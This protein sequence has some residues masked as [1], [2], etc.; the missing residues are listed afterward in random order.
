LRKGTQKRSGDAYARAGVDIAKVRAIHTSIAGILSS[1]FETRR[2]KF[3]EPVIGIG[4]YAGLIE[5][6]G[7]RLLA[8]HTDGV[9]TKVLVAQEMRKF[10]TIGIDCIAVTVNDLV[11]LGSEPVA[12]VDYIALQEEN[13]ALVGELARGLAEGA[14]QAGA[15]IVAGET[16]IVADLIKGVEGYAFDLISMGVGVIEKDS[17]I[18]GSKIREG[19]SVVGISSS[20]LHSNGYTLARRI[21][22]NRSL[23]EEVEE[24]GETI[25]QALLR[26]TRIY[27]APTLETVRRRELHGIANITGGAFSKLTRLVG[28]RALQFKLEQLESASTPPIFGFLKR[29]GNLSDAEMYRTFNMGVGLCLVTPP[30]E[31][32]AVLRDY[33]RRGFDG[34]QIGSVEK[35]RGVM[36][37]TKRIA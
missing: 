33:R 5:I 29:E 15:A 23:D 14:R 22:R 28:T 19:D 11:C 3:G 10:D 36:I 12:L 20:G 17:L 9:G 25:G 31:V 34:T 7:G 16:A 18:D 26:P 1:T 24:L 32:G 8:I 2:G 21:V 35:G 30:S 37:G 4:H 6:G 13:D 27:V